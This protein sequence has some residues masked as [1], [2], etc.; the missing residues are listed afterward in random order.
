MKTI[1][2]ERLNKRTGKT[3]VTEYVEVSQRV[4]FFN[5]NYPNG[6]IVTE[7][8]DD[9]DRI[10]FK[11]IVTPDCKEPERFFTG[12]SQASFNDQYSVVNKTSALENAETSAV[13]RAL[14][15]MGIG[16][17]DG[18]ASI[19]EINKAKNTEKLLNSKEE[20]LKQSIDSLK[21]DYKNIELAELQ[22]RV[23]KGK[24]LCKEYPELLKEFKFFDDYF[25]SLDE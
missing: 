12:H 19:D 17:I 3:T 5:K 13:G 11:A 1:K 9:T 21:K 8:Q 6:S 16:V 14:G 2:L 23:E 18:I 4:L 10:V 15:L 7:R 20:I 25:A 22:S 24:E